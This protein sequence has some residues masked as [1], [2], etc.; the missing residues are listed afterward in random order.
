MEYSAAIGDTWYYVL[1]AIELARSVCDQG[2]PAECLRILDESE[3]YQMVP[4]VEILVNRPA[5]RALA[6]AHLGQR[7]EAESL[8]RVALGYAIGTDFVDL[9]ANA[10][11][12]LAEIL[13][14]A[15]RPE[16][17][18]PLVGEAVELFDLKGNRVSAAR[19]RAVFE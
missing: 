10:L 16:A 5:T 13:H 14:L 18:A 6:L 1:A 9:H 12:V 7:D 4:D 19:A 2:R 15:G 8:A 3:H 17:A 11:L